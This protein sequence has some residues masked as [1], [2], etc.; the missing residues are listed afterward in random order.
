MSRTQLSSKCLGRRNRT[1]RLGAIFKRL[2][3]QTNPLPQFEIEQAP[4][5]IPMIPVA[6]AMLSKQPL[7]GAGVE[8][9]S[10]DCPWF[11]QQLLQVVQ[12]ASC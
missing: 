12:L 7:Y 10:L 4:D 2:A 9:S 5:P 11:K 1:L 3:I 6:R 8:V